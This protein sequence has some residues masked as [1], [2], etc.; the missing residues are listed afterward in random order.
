MNVNEVRARRLLKRL[1]PLTKSNLFLEALERLARKQSEETQGVVRKP[2]AGFTN[3][4]A[5]MEEQLKSYDQATAERVCRKLKAEYEGKRASCSCR[6]MVGAVVKKLLAEGAVLKYRDGSVV[7]GIAKQGGRAMKIA[8]PQVLLWKAKELVD[9]FCKSNGNKGITDA[10]I[11]VICKQ[12]IGQIPPGWE[13]FTI[14]D[15]A[16]Y[17][18][19]AKQFLTKMGYSAGVGDLTPD[20]NVITTASATEGG[21]I[22]QT[23]SDMYGVSG[24]GG[25]AFTKGRYGLRLQA[26]KRALKKEGLLEGE[27]I[28]VEKEGERLSKQPANVEEHTLNLEERVAACEGAL[29]ELSKFVST[30]AATAGKE[31]E[32]ADTAGSALAGGAAP[33]KAAEKRLSPDEILR[34]RGLRRVVPGSAVRKAAGGNGGQGTVFQTVLGSRR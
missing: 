27:D 11:D 28:P 14:P 24:P 18:A 9:K 16:S 25:G 6:S 2:F 31:A 10:Q 4:D 12:V 22:N 13:G 33:E 17:A 30:I 5:C 32:A 7:E 21:T 15:W 26:L 20:V 3:W 34:K 19:D 1:L 29:D 8:T 23:A